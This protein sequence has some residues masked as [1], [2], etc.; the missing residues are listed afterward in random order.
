MQ[1][2]GTNTSRF[3]PNVLSEEEVRERLSLC[4]GNPKIIDELYD[5]GRVLGNEAADRIRA[6]E[7]KSTSFAAYGA[8]IVTFLVSSASLWSKLGNEFSPWIVTC[9]GFCGLMCTC[10]SLRVLI[11]RGHELISE[12]EWL[13]TECLSQI[14]TL[15]QYRIL[16]MWGVMQSHD[17]FQREKATELQRAQVWLAGSVAYLVY[18]LF[19]IAVVRTFH[20]GSWISLWQSMVQ[21]HSWIPSWE[22]LGDWGCALVLGLIMALVIWRACRVRLI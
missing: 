3:T 12:D 6:L 11:L 19:Q 7:S 22:I 15:K 14:N 21:G 13:K 17:K 18:L 8:A 16:T 20:N 2:S 10:F 5:F 9:A 1:V 4:K